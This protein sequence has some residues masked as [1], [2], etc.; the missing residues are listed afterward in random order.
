[1]CVM[2]PCNFGLSILYS[3]SDKCQTGSYMVL[4]ILASASP[5][6]VVCSHVCLSHAGVKVVCPCLSLSVCVTSCFILSLPCLMWIVFSFASPVSISPDLFPLFPAASASLIILLGVYG[7]SLPLSCAGMSFCAPCSKRWLQCRRW[8]EKVQVHFSSILVALYC[9]CCD[10][11]GVN[12]RK[13]GHKTEK[14]KPTR[15]GQAKTESTKGD[16]GP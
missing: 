5:Q 1:M 12:D 11:F 16:I 3:P 8:K 6:S 13:I 2:D 14:Q 9:N 15:P 10:G 7:P 4:F